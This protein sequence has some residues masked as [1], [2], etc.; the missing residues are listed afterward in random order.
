MSFRDGPL[1]K[2]SPDSEKILLAF[3]SA[4][5]AAI[6]PVPAAF[7]AAKVARKTAASELKMTAAQ[8]P[9]NQGD[10]SA[11]GGSDKLTYDAWCTAV[12]VCEEAVR[13]TKLEYEAVKKDSA[14]KMLAKR[15]A[16]GPINLEWAFVAT[17]TGQLC[18]MFQRQM[19]MSGRRM[20]A[21]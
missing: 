19:A 3:T 20:Q 11:A 14:E 8:E 13:S 9:G 2:D 7:K 21:V 1:F 18:K 12:K 6:A 17:L 4:Q 10:D 5:D 16:H 15:S